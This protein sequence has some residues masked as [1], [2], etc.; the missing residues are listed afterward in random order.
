MT[1]TEGLGCSATLD[2]GRKSRGTTDSAPPTLANRLS[3]ERR[4]G[5]VGREQECTDFLEALENREL[6][7]IFLYGQVGVGKSTLLLEFRRLALAGGHKA[8]LLSAAELED[9]VR[10]RELVEVHA[11]RPTRAEDISGSRANRSVLLIDGVEQV[12][13]NHWFLRELLPTLGDD[14]LLVFAS[15]DGLPPALA[16][17]PA[18]SRLVR[19]LRLA[20]F[21]EAE[22][23]RFLELRGVPAAVQQHILELTAGYPLA[24]TVTADLVTRSYK[25]ELSIECLLDVQHALA[26][27]LCPVTV[28]AARQLALDVCSMAATTT[29][30]LLEFVRKSAR[31]E[32][33]GESLDLFNWLA[34]ESYIDWTPNGLRP[35]KLMRAALYTRL[36]RERPKRFDE[37]RD[38]LRKFFVDELETGLIPETAFVNLLFLDRDIPL[39]K[40][41][42]PHIEAVR[43]RHLEAAKMGDRAGVVEAIREAE[44]EESA[45]LASVALQRGWGQ[46]EVSGSPHVDSLFHHSRHGANVDWASLNPEDPV[47]GLL[48]NFLKERPLSES[49]EVLLFRWFMDRRSYQAPSSGVL[50]IVA[51]QVQMILA[52]KNVAYS[53]CVFRSPGDW[54]WLTKTTGVQWETVGRFQQGG[55]EYSL[56]AN[57]WKVHPLQE[58]LLAVTRGTS[59]TEDIPPREATYDELRIKVRERVGRLRAQ[60]KLTPREAEILEQ[61][62]LGYSLDDIGKQLA[63]RPRTV[64]FHQENLLRKTGANS[65]VELF[66]KLM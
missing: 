33:D 26:R 41:F 27:L 60:L 65:R 42:T 8:L 38:V 5:F 51:R 21:D 52:A 7:L 56:L 35:H 40:P 31:A 61:L 39:V 1:T 12:D 57:S 13:G 16:L 34:R 10:A 53:F 36:R 3:D 23:R 2:G 15:R 64:K 66:R 17:D 46:F 22:G 50:S 48:K 6:S 54:V 24:L 4:R 14:V 49:E 29:A 9:Q 47:T 28:C 44:G 59:D 58:Q 62:C 30:E 55:H 19:R 25:N 63:I 18:W 20:P 37:L 43:A 45:A 32:P 11:M